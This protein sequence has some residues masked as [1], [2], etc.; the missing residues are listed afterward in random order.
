MPAG[1]GAPGPGGTAPAPSVAGGSGAGGGATRLGDARGREGPPERGGLP[2]SGA[3][4][5]ALLESSTGARNRRGQRFPARLGTG[6]AV[7]VPSII[8]AESPLT[9]TPSRASLAP[10]RGDTGA[11]TGRGG[12]PAWRGGGGFTSQPPTHG[13]PV[14]SSPLAGAVSISPALLCPMVLLCRVHQSC[15]ALSI[16]PA[17]PCPSVALCRV[18]QSRCALCAHT[19]RCCGWSCRETP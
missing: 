6:S 15:S 3:P 11:A 16:S 18:C 1:C 14:L 9:S 10:P 8:P 2:G 19:A 13:M 4:G 12:G 7:P 17:V 5:R